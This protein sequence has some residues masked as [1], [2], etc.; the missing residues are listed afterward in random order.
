MIRFPDEGH[1]LS[2]SGRIDRRIQRIDAIIAW[3]EEHA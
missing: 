1:E 3:F 2:R